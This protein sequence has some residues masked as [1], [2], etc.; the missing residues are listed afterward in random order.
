MLIFGYL[1]TDKNISFQMNTETLLTT[2]RLLI[3][4]LVLADN[5]FILEL[6]NTDGWIKFIGNRKITS[7]MEATA[8]IQKILDNPNVNYWVVKLKD[9]KTAIGVVTFIKR[10][11]LDH[12][13]IGFAFLPDFCGSG[14]AYEATLAVLNKMVQQHNHSHILATTIPENSNSIKL[15]EKLGLQFEKEIK[16]EKETL[17]VYAVSIEKL[18]T[19]YPYTKG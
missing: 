8:Y 16:V 3:E 18:N 11:Y 19:P 17:H 1:Q 10:D 15:L 13:D 9:D 12:H 14:Y 7:P 6:V 2:D 5:N 4:P